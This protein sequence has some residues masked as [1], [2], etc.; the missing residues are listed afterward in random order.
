MRAPALVGVGGT[1]EWRDTDVEDAELVRRARAGDAWGRAAI[2]HRYAVEIANLAV[3]LLRDRDAAGDVVQDTFVTGFETMGGLRDPSKL[4]GWLRVIAVRHVHRRFRRRRLLRALGI[5][6]APGTMAL[7]DLAMVDAD[8]ETRLQLRRADR[9]L[10]TL[11]DR[12]RMVW[13]LRV[14][15]GES[16]PEIAGA[17][18]VSLATVKRDLVV[19]EDALRGVLEGGES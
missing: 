12:V 11:S 5:G 19:A 1:V 6:P 7:E 9:A 16:L 3:R 13:T 10:A 2:Y 4:R 8:Q 14:I 18:G 17:C 15:E